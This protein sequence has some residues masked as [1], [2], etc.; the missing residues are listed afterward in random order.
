MFPEIIKKIYVINLKSC[1]D[2]KKHIIE[3]FKNVGI[4]NYDFFRCC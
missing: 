4:E 1:V 3:E 2:R